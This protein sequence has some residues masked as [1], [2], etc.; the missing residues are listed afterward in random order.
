MD[1]LIVYNGM[2]LEGEIYSVELFILPFNMFLIDLFLQQLAS[3]RF[4]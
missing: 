4:R 2:I 3:L 1:V